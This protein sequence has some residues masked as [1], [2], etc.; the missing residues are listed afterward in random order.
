[1]TDAQASWKTIADEANRL[2]LTCGDDLQAQ[3]EL[4]HL[5]DHCLDFYM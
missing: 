3:E 4:T 1:M 2:A 5:R